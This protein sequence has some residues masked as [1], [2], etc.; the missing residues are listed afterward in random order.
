MTGSPRPASI[1]EDQ[2]VASLPQDG[3][4][5]FAAAKELASFLAAPETFGKMER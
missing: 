5:I 3:F 1:T 2:S 4:F